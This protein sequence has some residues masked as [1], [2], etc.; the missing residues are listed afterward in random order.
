MVDER[1]YDEGDGGDDRG[2]TI[3]A[4]PS[5]PAAPRVSVLAVAAFAVPDP[6]AVLEDLPAELG[7]DCMARRL[8]SVSRFSRCRSVRISAACW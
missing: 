7:E 2:V 6:L 1:N 8:V 3:F 5:A 4:D